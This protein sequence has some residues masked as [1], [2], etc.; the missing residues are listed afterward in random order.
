MG[1]SYARVSLGSEARGTDHRKAVRRQV[2]I[3]ASFFSPGLGRCSVGEFTHTSAA[4]VR[5]QTSGL[6]VPVRENTTGPSWRMGPRV[7][8]R[9][10]SLFPHISAKGHSLPRMQ[11]HTSEDKSQ[12]GNP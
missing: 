3:P 2:G 8:Q 6:G 1:I 10:P 7:P 11:V 9:P 12:D 5:T 4:F